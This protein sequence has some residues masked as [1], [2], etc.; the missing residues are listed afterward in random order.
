MTLHEASLADWETEVA[1]PFALCQCK[2]HSIFDQDK[3]K[4]KQ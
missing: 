3:Y 4:T 2:N 1:V